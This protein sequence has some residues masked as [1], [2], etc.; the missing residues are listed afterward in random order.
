MVK[1]ISKNSPI[2]YIFLSGSVDFYLEQQLKKL[3]SYS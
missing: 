1:R 2:N 3:T